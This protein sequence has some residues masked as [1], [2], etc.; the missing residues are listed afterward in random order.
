MTKSYG[1]HVETISLQFVYIKKKD[2]TGYIFIDT[3]LT[4]L[5]KHTTIVTFNSKCLLRHVCCSAC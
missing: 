5:P 3:Q 1:L 2:D 4:C